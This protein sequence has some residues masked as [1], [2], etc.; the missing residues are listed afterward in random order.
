LK[1]ERERDWIDHPQHSTIPYQQQY[2]MGTS[3]ACGAT[4]QVIDELCTPPEVCGENAEEAKR[5]HLLKQTTD[6]GANFLQKTI[7]RDKPLFVGI[8]IMVV[9]MRIP[10]LKYILYPFMIFSTWVHEM[11]HGRSG[12]FKRS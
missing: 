1:E 12:A 6:D 9:L 3:N 11:S 2:S 8:L 10:Y 5:Q 7:Q 4:D